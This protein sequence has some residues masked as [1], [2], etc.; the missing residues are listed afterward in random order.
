MLKI[1]R[2]FLIT[3]FS[4]LDLLIIKLFSAEFVAFAAMQCVWY[5]AE[6]KQEAVGTAHLIFHERHTPCDC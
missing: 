6:P 1:K 5:S 4:D 2:T 3:H